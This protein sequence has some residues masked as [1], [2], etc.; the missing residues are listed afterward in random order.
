MRFHGYIYFLLVDDFLVCFFW[1]IF[2]CVFLGGFFGGFGVW[3]VDDTQL[4]CGGRE[5]SILCSLTMMS[6]VEK[7]LRP[8]AVTRRL[9]GVPVRVLGVPVSSFVRGVTDRSIDGPLSQTYG[10]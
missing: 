1:W 9:M 3:G 6:L 5:R 4:F 7:A 8:A 2:W 10:E